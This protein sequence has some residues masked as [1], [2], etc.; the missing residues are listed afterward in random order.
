MMFGYRSW[1]VA[2]NTQRY[3]LPQMPNQQIGYQLQ[4]EAKETLECLER[5]Q[6]MMEI[7][8]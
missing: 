6:E 1:M 7:V 4:D 2:E 5:F 8:N 3:Y